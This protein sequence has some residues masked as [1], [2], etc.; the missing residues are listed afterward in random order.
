MTGSGLTAVQ[1][2]LGPIGSRIARAADG[3]GFEFVG[4]ID[5][6]PDKVGRDLGAVAGFDDEIGVEVTDNAE[7]ALAKNPDIVFHSTVSSLEVA[8]PQLVRVLS[9]EANVVST[10]EELA[11]PW[12]SNASLGEDLDDVATEHGVTLLGTGINPGFAMDTLPA[13]LSTPMEAVDAVTVERV[14]DAG[15]R[16]KPLQEKV[17][18]GVSV[19]TFEADIAD[20]AGH[21]GSTESVAMLADA[22]GFELDEIDEAIEPVVADSVIETEHVRVRSGEV[23]GI[24]Q[25]ARGIIDG[26]AV[27]SL[28][29]EMYVGADNPRDRVEFIGIPSVSITVEDGYHGDIATAA[30]VTNVASTVVGAE[31]GLATMLDIPTSFTRRV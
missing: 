23:A 31:P 30:V 28:D 9:A 15:Q 25:T 22:L 20:Q 21:V 5:I 13:V 7:A 17:G 16:R 27:I 3:R 24:R 1:F 18:A 11:Y 4:A 8:K 10:T 29:L 26:D 6:D 2:G 12:W 14:Q 19:E